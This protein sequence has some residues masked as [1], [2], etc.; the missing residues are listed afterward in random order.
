MINKTYAI[1]NT[2]TG[3]ITSIVETSD[4]SVMDVKTSEG[5]SWVQDDSATIEDHYVDVS[6]SPPLYEVEVKPALSTVASWDKV[7]IE[8]TTGTVYTATLSGL[9]NP[10]TVNIEEISRVIGVRIIDN[11]VTDGSAVFTSPVEGIFKVTA[12][13]AGYRDYEEFISVGQTIGMSLMEVFIDFDTVNIP[14]T[15]SVDTASVAITT[16]DINIQDYDSESIDL[17]T[18][19]TT[20]NDVTVKVSTTIAVDTAAVYVTP[21]YPTIHQNTAVS[22]D[23]AAVN[24]TA[25]DVDVKNNMVQDID[26]MTVAT[27]MN[28][29]AIYPDVVELDLMTVYTTTKNPG[30][31]EG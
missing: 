26:L 31:I 19:S 23:L 29:V 9:P 21:R 12:K 7:C 14:D 4:E 28:D 16:N 8:D 18:V 20:M 11:D 13:S 17:M 30:V 27:T 22:L 10:S 25:N 1:F 5:E 6:G 3:E 24:I 15:I 2:T